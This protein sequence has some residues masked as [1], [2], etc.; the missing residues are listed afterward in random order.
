VSGSAS[1]GSAQQEQDFEEK[2]ATE[3]PLEQDQAQRRRCSRAPEP[4]AESKGH[5][6][7]GQDDE[8]ERSRKA[9]IRALIAVVTPYQQAR[10]L[11]HEA[12]ERNR[13][14]RMADLTCAMD[15]AP[16]GAEFYH[17]DISPNRYDDYYPELAR[18]GFAEFSQNEHSYAGMM[19]FPVAPAQPAA[20]GDAQLM[21]VTYGEPI[22]RGFFEP[23]DFFDTAEQIGEHMAVRVGLPERWEVLDVRRLTRYL[24]TSPYYGRGYTWLCRYCQWPDPFALAHNWAPDDP[25]IDQHGYSQGHE[26]CRLQAML[27]VEAEDFEPVLPTEGV[28]G[29]VWRKE[30]DFGDAKCSAHSDYRGPCSPCQAGHFYPEVSHA[31]CGHFYPEVVVVAVGGPGGTTHHYHGLASLRSNAIGTLRN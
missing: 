24:E 13:M 5:S 8:F 4:A 10:E 23:L 6:A 29:G 15:D 1:G 17:D 27:R 16:G 30:C 22:V 7:A 14:L 20:P 21:H 28:P 19:F 18:S 26:R 11:V 9:S 12:R 31:H 25:L 3:V 2:K